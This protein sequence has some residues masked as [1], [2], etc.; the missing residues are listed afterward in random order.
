MTLCSKEVQEL[1]QIDVLDLSDESTTDAVW[2]G[3]GAL[4][5]LGKLKTLRCALSPH[6]SY[7]CPCEQLSLVPPSAKL[8]ACLHFVFALPLARLSRAQ[9]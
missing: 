4:L 8:I 3:I 5:Q 6:A 7:L 9:D 1:L 2:D